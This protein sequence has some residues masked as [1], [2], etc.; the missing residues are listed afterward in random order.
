MK[1]ILVIILF[2]CIAFAQAQDK[3]TD[4][5]E[6]PK[7]A[8]NM[9]KGN[10]FF[11]KD[12]FVEAEAEFRI[13]A[14]KSGSSQA[15]YNLGTTIY[16]QNQ[17]KESKFA[18]A[19]ALE[20]ATTKEEKHKASHNLGNVFMKEKKYAEA[21]EA[22][23]NALRNNP[24]DE[25]TRYNYALAKEMLEKN[26]PPPNDD[27]GDKDQNKDQQ[28]DQDQQNQKDQQNQDQNKN[29]KDQKDQDDNQ[30]KPN[31]KEKQ[32]PNKGNQDNQD[33]PQGQPKPQGIS[34]ESLERLLEAVNNEEKKVQDKINA[35]KVKGK[36]TK[37]DKDW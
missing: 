21:V 11:Q 29:Q 6:P 12:D 24:R 30:G 13:A 27:K 18:F 10:K 26:P 25:K 7:D 22:Y 35:E 33:N 14:S 23:K 2:S 1:N 8:K 15:K 37:T 3:N 5:K 28:K 31:E 9:E 4:K 16:K 20:K 36:P 17:S 32:D 19:E 34:K